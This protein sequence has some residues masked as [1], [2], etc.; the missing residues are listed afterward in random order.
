MIVEKIPLEC[1]LFSHC[2][3]KTKVKCLTTKVLI[4]NLSVE[5]DLTP[6]VGLS[7]SH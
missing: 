4:K 3:E 1:Y 2:Q 6:S 5:I 7:V